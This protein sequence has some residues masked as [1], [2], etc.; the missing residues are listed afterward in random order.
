MWSLR[1][2]ALVTL[3]LFHG[4]VCRFAVPAW[5]QRKAG[6][7]QI[8]ATRLSRVAQH[9][10]KGGYPLC[11]LFVQTV[12]Q[13]DEEFMCILLDRQQRQQQQRVSTFHKHFAATAAVMGRKC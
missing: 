3:A 9:D 1:T 13:K 2:V 8:E 10:S 11:E 7:V 12:Q 4:H 6:D 5:L